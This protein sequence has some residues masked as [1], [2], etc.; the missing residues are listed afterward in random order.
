MTEWAEKE[1]EL[2]LKRETAAIENDPEETDEDMKEMGKQYAGGCY[3]SALKAYKSLM[4]DKHSGYSFGVT[5]GI[6]KRLLDGYPLTP[7]EDVPESWNLIH[8]TDDV[9]TYQ[10]KRCHS[11]FK[12]VDKKTGEA[13][14]SDVERV[15]CTNSAGTCWTNGFVSR[16][17]SEMYPIEMPYWPTGR[18]YVSAFD[19]AVS[20]IPGE[21]DTMEIKSVKCPDGKVEVLNWYFKEVDEQFTSIDADEYNQRYKQFHDNVRRRAK[22]VDKLEDGERNDSAETV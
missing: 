19:F 8:E 3:A 20:G 5:R 7:I 11:L 21:F 16:K 2:A 9:A 18:Y 17:I 14:F 12:D 4:E 10:C 22:D 1:V 6:L 15:V 13:T